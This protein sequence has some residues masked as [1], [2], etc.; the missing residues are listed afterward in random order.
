MKARVPNAEPLQPD[1]DNSIAGITEERKAEIDTLFYQIIPQTDEEKTAMYM[2]LPKKQLCE[3][4][5]QCN[6]HIEGLWDEKN[7][8]K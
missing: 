5:I 4:L 6:K 7:R 8:Y 1:F 2:K 3:M